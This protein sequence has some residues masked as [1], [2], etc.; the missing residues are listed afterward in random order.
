MKTDPPAH[1]TLAHVLRLIAELIGE[2]KMEE[3]QWS[4]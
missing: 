1:K 2:E 4:L 3:A